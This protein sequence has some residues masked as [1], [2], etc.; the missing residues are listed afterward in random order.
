MSEKTAQEYARFRLAELH[1]RGLSPWQR[2]IVREEIM[3]AWAH[4]T[5]EMKKAVQLSLMGTEEDRR[6]RDRGVGE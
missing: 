3:L 5:G 1:S 6:K 4:A 2:E